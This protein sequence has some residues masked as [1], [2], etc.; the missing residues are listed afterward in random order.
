L[1]DAC[2]VTCQILNVSEIP[3]NTVIMKS[4]KM[5]SSYFIFMYQIF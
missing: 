4:N 2:G 1:S 5:I 3:T